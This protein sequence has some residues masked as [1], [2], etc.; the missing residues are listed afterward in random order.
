M[1][2]TI[3]TPH[4]LYP[5]QYLICYCHYVYL[6]VTIQ[7]RVYRSDLSQI[8]YKLYHHL[9][10]QVPYVYACYIVSSSHPV[11]M[12]LH[13]AVYTFPTRVYNWC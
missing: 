7:Y 11:A 13:Y 2:F 4:L 12:D 1:L 10:L 6:T 8:A 9:V 5:Y 3:C